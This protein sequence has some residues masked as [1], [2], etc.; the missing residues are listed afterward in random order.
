MLV[1]MSLAVES[2][3]PFSRRIGTDRYEQFVAS[4][5]TSPVSGIIYD[6]KSRVMCGM[7]L[8]GL[9]TGCLDLETT[10]LIGYSTIFNSHVPRGGPVNG[11]LFGVRVGGKTW[12]LTTGSAKEYDEPRIDWAREGSTAPEVSTPQLQRLNLEPAHVVDN[13]RYFGHYPVADLD[14]V[15]NSPVQVWLRAWSP[16]IPGDI[17]ASMIPGAVFEVRLRNASEEVQDGVVLFSFD[18]PTV[19][20]AGGELARREE[21]PATL[22]GVHVQCEECS[23]AMGVIG[24]DSDVWTGAS[25]GT[26]GEAWAR[27]GEHPL[28]GIE[29]ARGGSVVVP[30]ALAPGASTRRVFLLSWWAPRWWGEGSPAGGGNRYTHRY[31]TEWR[32]A[33]EVATKLAVGHDELLARILSWQEVIYTSEDLPAWLRSAL[34]NVLHLITEDGL[35]AVARDVGDWCKADDG[36]FGMIECPRGYAQIECIPCSFYGAVPLPYFFPTLARSTLQGYRHYQ[37]PNGEVP[38]VFGGV[39][40]AASWGRK[41]CCEMIYPSPGYQTSLNGVCYVALMDRYWQSTG[42]RTVLEEFY[43]SV[44]SAVQFTIGLRP[45]YEDIGQRVLA[46]PSGD[47]GTEW[48]EAPEPGWFGITN[49]V[50]GLR[51][52]MLAIAERLAR[53]VGDSTFAGKCREWRL[54][55]QAVMETEMWLARYYRTCYDPATERKSDLIFA[56]QLDGEWLVRFH[57]LAGVFEPDRVAETLETIWNANVSLTAHG[58]VN[59]ALPS[60][61][62]AS[63]GGY[64]PYGMFPPEV[65]MLAMTYMYAGQ[66]EHGTDA[67]RCWENIEC[68]Q[69]LTW[70]QPNMSHGDQ[71]TGERVFGADY[72]QNML[73]WAL[74]AALRGEA[75]GSVVQGDGLVARVLRA[76]RLGC[77]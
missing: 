5:F 55:G 23:F 57:G 49:H 8:G 59:Y 74:P 65:L 24:A 9:G 18:G 47:S 7:P 73:L 20:E 70:D 29:R 32:S 25:L 22:Q 67:R 72:Y 11:P 21:L 68:R 27:A 28:D 31:S 19:S 40:A 4:G 56:Y 41:N 53:A 61:E 1:Q 17:P 39:T 66:R 44:K 69:G 63:V 16:F 75:V 60:G 15:M 51:L 33:V 52:A 30:F 45:E 46:M 62:L 34:V 13:V 35:W 54:A 71:D 77:P 36:L 48:F 50:G 42:D 14:F 37:Y 10:G 2:F 58:A 3:L 26:D 12:V 43:Q 64:G 6:S 76:G 38:W